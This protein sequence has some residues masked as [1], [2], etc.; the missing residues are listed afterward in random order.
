MVSRLLPIL[1]LLAC[2]MASAQNVRIDPLDNNTADDDFAPAYTNHGRVIIFTTDVGGDGQRLRSMERTSSGWTG[3]SKLLGDVND[4]THSGSG[5]LTPDG[6]F[7]IFA[8]FEND[9]DG[10]GRTDLYSARK[11][12]GRWV[13]VKNLGASINSAS[14]DAHPSITSDGRTLYFVSDR[15]GGNGETDIYFSVSDGAVW[16]TPKVLAGINTASSE[17]SP[18][19]GSDGRTLFFSSNR[20]GGAGGFDVYVAK[21]SGSSATDVRRIGDPINTSA[22]EMFYSA[23]PNSDQALFSRTT[24]A[25]TY[26]NF[27]AVPNPFPTEPV[28]LVEGIVSDV[29]TQVPLGSNITVTDLATGKKVASMRSDDQTGQYYVTLTPGRVY[30]ITASAPN[31]VFHSERYEIPPGAKGKTIKKDIKLSPL[32]DGNAQLLVFFDYDKSELKSESFPELERIIELLRENPK[33]HLRFDGHTD[34]QGSD[35]Y[36]DRLS[37]KRAEAVRDYIVAGGVV[38]SRMEAKGFGK[39][40]PMVQGVSDEARASNRRVEMKVIQ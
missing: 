23:L 28:T 18:I 11:V 29:N 31:Y 27:V 38:A 35:E 17:M 3:A 21:V 34:D 26:D 10:L 1:L 25:G 9:V 40:Q 30:S 12:D 32:A 20:P 24:A 39:R 16:S 2:T 37:Q 19:I 15:P 5:T 7:I 13:D 8:S 22:D 14:Y 4:A 36:N 6:Q 33:V